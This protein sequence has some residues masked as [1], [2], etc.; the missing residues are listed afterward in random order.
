MKRNPLK[1]VAAAAGALTLAVGLAFTAAASATSAP[2]AQPS[3]DEPLVSAYEQVS[4]NTNWTLAKTIQPSWKPAGVTYEWEGLKVYGGRIYMSVFDHTDNNGHLVVLDQNTGNLIKDISFADGNRTHA[5]GLS[6]DGNYAY[7]PLAVDSPHSS[8]DI[9]RINISSYKVTNLFTV[10]Y[11]HVGGVTYDPATH[12]IVGQ[13]WDSRTF[14]E[15]TLTGRTVSTWN[16]PTDY[17]GY[18]DCQYVIYNKLLC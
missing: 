8:A 16:N 14:Y 11:D 7:V 5:G 17:V 15:W 10:S 4:Q 9:L 18:Q 6:V 12:L 13:D 1:L 2:A 3:A